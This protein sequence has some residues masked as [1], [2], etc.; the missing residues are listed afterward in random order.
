[1]DPAEVVGLAGVL[2][3]QLRALFAIHSEP[4]HCHLLTD[5]ATPAICLT[6]KA[7]PKPPRAYDRRRCYPAAVSHIATELDNCSQRLSLSHRPHPS[8][9]TQR[10]QLLHKGSRRRATRQTGTAI[11]TSTTTTDDDD[12]DDNDDDI[13]LSRPD[14]AGCLMRRSTRYANASQVRHEIGVGGASVLIGTGT[15]RLC[16]RDPRRGLPTRQHRPLEGSA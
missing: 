13:S 7:R 14:P 3:C 6:T 11:F 2:G 4:C 12:N 15:G 8:A 1:M 10:F 16:R 9:K 5:C